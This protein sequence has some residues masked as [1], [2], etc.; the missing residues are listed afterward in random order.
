MDEADDRSVR[1]RLSVMDEADDR[2]VRE[3]LSVVDEA[4]HRGER[5]CI[6]DECGFLRVGAEAHSDDRCK[7][8]CGKKY[9]FHNKIPLSLK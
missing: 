6:M 2:S 9:F 8:N 1:E 7:Q 3:R 5:L 4:D